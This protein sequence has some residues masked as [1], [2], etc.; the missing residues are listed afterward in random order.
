MQ[1][2]EALHMSNAT[3]SPRTRTP[4]QRQRAIDTALTKAQEM[5]RAG[6]LPTLVRSFTS[7]DQLE[8]QQHYTVPSR[9]TQGTYYHVTVR[10]DADGLHTLCH[11]CEAATAGRLCWH[12]A[13]CWLAALGRLGCHDGQQPVITPATAPDPWDEEAFAA[14]V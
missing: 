6:I 11:D 9:M 4:E 12:R 2:C 1:N 3:T 10:A 14:I 8:T 13:A 5:A 7:P